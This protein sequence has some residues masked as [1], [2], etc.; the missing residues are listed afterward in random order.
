[1]RISKTDLAAEKYDQAKIV[2]PSLFTAQDFNAGLYIYGDYVYY[3]TPTTDKAVED[4]TVQNDW[5]DF[6]RAKLDGTDTMSGYYFRLS[7]NAAN[8]RFVQGEDKTVY[9]MYVESGALKSF[10]TTTKKTTV[11]VKN[12]ACISRAI[13]CTTQRRRRIKP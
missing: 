13:T 6:K 8:Y 12:A 4:G 11:L 2:V 5:I 3:A 1:M 10:N 7:N 9:C